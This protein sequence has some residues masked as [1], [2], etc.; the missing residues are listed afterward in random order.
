MRTRGAR[1][2]PDDRDGHP[3]PGG[4]VVRRPRRVPRRRP[5]RRRPRRSDRRLRPRPHQ[6]TSGAD[7]SC[8][9]LTIKELAAQQAAPAQHRLRRVPR[10]R[11]PRR[12]PRVHRHRHEHLRPASS[13]MPTTALDA[14]VRAP[15]EHPDLGFGEPGP[16]STPRS[17]SS[18]AAVDGVDQVALRINGYAQIVDTT[19]SPSAT[20][21]ER[22]TFGVELGR[23]SPTST[24]TG[25][26]T[27][28]PRR[29]TT[30]SSSTRTRA[31]EGRLRSR[32]PHD[33]ADQARAA[34]VHHRRHRQVR[35]PPTRR[36]APPSVLF[37]D[38]TRPQALLAEPG[39]VDG[40]DV[41]ATTTASRRTAV[42]AAVAG[43]RR[44]RR[45]GDHRRTRGDQG[46]P[47]RSM[48]EN[49]A[50]FATFMLVFAGDRD[51]RRCVHHQQHLLDHRRP[52][53]PGDGDAAGHR[54]EPAVRSSDPCSLEAVVGR[55]R[56]L[57]GSAWPAASVSP[58]G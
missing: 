51:V 43:R 53:H 42:V 29:P 3:R 13:P 23:R 18:I 35:R 7:R 46:G 37:T 19:A 41:S 33:R 34:T 31:D 1:V 30:R 45:R 36:P 26:S 58:P 12:H 2:R 57:R 11:L 38:R 9:R 10:R 50:G 40:I 6:D 47:G 8:S 25:C 17:S 49:I 14:Y 5:H 21:R 54:C 22:P 56:R 27:A 39:E 44:R 52:A 32:R 24:R 20:S 48:H 16:A 28:A 55:H 15:S 4:R